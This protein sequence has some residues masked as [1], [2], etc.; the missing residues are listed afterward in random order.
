MILLD[1]LFWS[2]TGRTQQPRTCHV[3]TPSYLG[4]ANHPTKAKLNKTA[5]VSMRLQAFV[6]GLYLVES[7]PDHSCADSEGRFQ[8]LATTC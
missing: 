1:H 2:H 8:A 4:M 7:Q 6:Q 3:C 5:H